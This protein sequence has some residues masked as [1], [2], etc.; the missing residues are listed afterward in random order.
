[1]GLG[2]WNPRSTFA[3]VKASSASEHLEFQSGSKA[4]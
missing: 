1:M 3:D 2:K 4:Q